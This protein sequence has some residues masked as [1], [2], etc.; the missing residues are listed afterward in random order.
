MHARE[1]FPG[2]LGLTLGLL[3]LG[4]SGCKDKGPD[5]E[6]LNCVEQPCATTPAPAECQCDPGMVCEAGSC[7]ACSD[8]S[9]CQSGVCHPSG[10]CE[11]LPC[12]IDE[13]CPIA[14]ICDGGQC[15]FAANDGEQVDAPCGIAAIYFA[16]DS[17]KLTPNNQERLMSAAPCLIETLAGRTLI[18]EGYDQHVSLSERR[19]ASVR[20]FLVGRGVSA[21]RISTI[22]FGKEQPLDPG[23]SEEAWQKNRNG[24]TAIVSGAL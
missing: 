18:V 17:A 23:S 24:R 4:A 16:A 13:H 6:D 14:E 3:L 2:L 1:L 21:D 20:D 8:A 19:A 22:S 12:A 7:R 9:Q 15:V 5:R 10:R 11:P